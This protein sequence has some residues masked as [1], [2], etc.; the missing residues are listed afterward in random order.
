MHRGMNPRPLHWHRDAAR[1]VGAPAWCSRA[2]SL[3]RPPSSPTPECLLSWAPAVPQLDSLALPGGRGPS[4]I[5]ACR[6]VLEMTEHIQG[7][8]GTHCREAAGHPHPELPT[9]TGVPPSQPLGG[10]S[11]ASSSSDRDP[12]LCPRCCEAAGGR[13][14]KCSQEQAELQFQQRSRGGCMTQ[15]P[16]GFWSPS[17]PAGAGDSVKGRSFPLGCCSQRAEPPSWHHSAG[18][19]CFPTKQCCFL[20]STPPAFFGMTVVGTGMSCPDVTP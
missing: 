6:C 8:S 16:G 7:R 11:R 2:L 20:H 4:W 12:C 13:T 5:R 15:F 3:S 19:N 17:L 14:P 1:A 10:C 18:R 9:P